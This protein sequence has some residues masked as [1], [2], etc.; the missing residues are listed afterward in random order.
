MSWRVFC[1]VF[2]QRIACF[3]FDKVR[4]RAIVCLESG[5]DVDYFRSMNSLMDG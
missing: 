2:D 3:A 1:T 5:C 4:T